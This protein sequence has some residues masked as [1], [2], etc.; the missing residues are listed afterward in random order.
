MFH[1]WVWYSDSWSKIWSATSIWR[2]FVTKVLHRW[3]SGD[4]CLSP[5]VKDSMQTWRRVSLKLAHKRGCY[6]IV[7][8]ALHDAM[9]SYNA[10]WTSPN[11]SEP[12]WYNGRLFGATMPPRQYSWPCFTEGK[13]GLKCNPNFEARCVSH[14]CF[15]YPIL[16]LSQA[17]MKA[18][19]SV[20][21]WMLHIWVS[22]RPGVSLS[23][24]PTV[25][26]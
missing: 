25:T 20:W 6:M 23:C 1:F 8:R 19:L 22:A 3:I 9:V 7:S 10:H 17:L 16:W 21:D 12:P 13:S 5:T 14:Q 2:N 26:P 15:G 18:L 11:T 24:L 4:V